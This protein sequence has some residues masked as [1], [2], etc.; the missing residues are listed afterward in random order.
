MWLSQENNL[1]GCRVNDQ[2]E[3]EVIKRAELQEKN[4]VDP[5]RYSRVRAIFEESQELYY[6]ISR[7]ACKTDCVMMRCSIDSG[8]RKKPG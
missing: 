4:S 6:R 1:R 2:V 7:G 8:M 5:A 3:S